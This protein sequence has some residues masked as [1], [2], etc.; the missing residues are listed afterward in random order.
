MGLYI[1][2]PTAVGLYFSGA[3]LRFIFWWNFSVTLLFLVLVYIENR[4]KRAMAKL[5]K[6][7]CPLAIFKK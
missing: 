4:Q 1:L 5:L 7:Q 3:P 6:E 2:L